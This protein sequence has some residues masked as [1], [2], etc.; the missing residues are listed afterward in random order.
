MLINSEAIP[1]ATVGEAYVEDEIGMGERDSVQ[2]EDKVKSP[3][4]TPAL[5]TLICTSLI[6]LTIKSKLK[7]CTYKNLNFRKVT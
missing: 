3:S 6:S 2:E 5:G 7:F 1:E 4:S